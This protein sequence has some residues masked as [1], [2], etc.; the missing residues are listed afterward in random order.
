MFSVRGME[1][2]DSTLFLRIFSY[3]LYNYVIVLLFSTVKLRVLI[4]TESSHLHISKTAFSTCF[5]T[6]SDTPF[7]SFGVLMTF[8]VGNRRP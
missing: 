1:G 5:S 8:I 7:L 6:V 3:F 2:L 4:L